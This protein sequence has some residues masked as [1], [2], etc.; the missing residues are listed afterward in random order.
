MNRPVSTRSEPAERAGQLG[1]RDV[2]VA[3]DVGEHVR[4]LTGR[5]RVERESKRNKALAR[6]DLIIS[7][8]TEKLLIVVENKLH[9]GKTP[10]QLAKYRQIIESDSQFSDY[11]KIF[12][13]LTSKHSSKATKRK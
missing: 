4:A 12:V 3:A 5:A 9:A 11:Q 6:I 1:A 10:G 2:R 13:F 7:I 8:P